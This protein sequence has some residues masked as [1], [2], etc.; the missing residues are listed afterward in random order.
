MENSVYILNPDYIFRNDI[1]R[2]LVYT[3]SNTI[4][5]CSRD[6]LSKIHPTQAMILSFFSQNRLLS[7]NIKLISEFLNLS[8][9]KT[10]QLIFPFIENPTPL[11][12]KIKERI[13]SFP[14]NIIIKKNNHIENISFSPSD[15]KCPSIDLETK[16]LFSGPLHLTLMLTNKCVTRCKYCYADINTKY[17]EALSTDKIFNIIHEAHALG[18]KA[19][20]LIG[21]EVLLHKD[22]HRILKETVK[23]D[24][25]SDVISTKVPITKDI[26]DK[27]KDAQFTEKIQLSLDSVSSDVLQEALCVNNSY[28]G[29][30]INGIQLL[31]DS[32]CRYKIASVITKYNDNPKAMLDLYSF[33]KTLKNIKRWSITPAINTLYKSHHEFTKIKTDRIRLEK[34]YSYIEK[35]IIPNSDIGIDL[36][37]SCL[38]RAY[39]DSGKGSSSFKGAGCSAL[40]SHLFILPDG[41]VTICEQLYWNPN[42]IIGNIKKNSLSEIWNSPKAMALAHMKKENIQDKS[43][44]HSCG[45]FQ[46]CFDARNRC[47]ADIIKAYGDDKWDYP[48]PRC[49]KA[50]KMIYNLQF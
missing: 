22:W 44:C 18:L 32:G 30:V 45:Q 28:L 42:F 7:E 41:E 43:K 26:I 4:T 21:G 9:E 47:W 25:S 24:M 46:D 16:R 23:L 6:W 48:D 10:K 34:L 49:K 19:F 27:F 12:N 17:N 29:K 14:K 13:I 40:N 11:R 20:H 36:D 39:Y 1:Q 2:I 5:D 15:M 38:D 3:K 50:P 33:I 35:E 31:D 37:R 8:Y